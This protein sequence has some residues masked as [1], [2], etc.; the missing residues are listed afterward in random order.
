MPCITTAY[1]GGGR[2]LRVVRGVRVPEGAEPLDSGASFLGGDAGFF[3]FSGGGGRV[4][5]LHRSEGNGDE[6]LEPFERRFLVAGLAPV[7]LT[8]DPKDSAGTDPGPQ[9][10]PKPCPLLGRDRTRRIQVP[11]RLDP[12]LKLV[13]VLPAWSAGMRRTELDLV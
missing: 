5:L 8:R 1:Q 4:T 6:R 12:R 10:G 13:H 9:S 11:T 3:G 7:A 2:L